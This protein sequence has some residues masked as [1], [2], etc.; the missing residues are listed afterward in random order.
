MH[1]FKQP[2]EA[3]QDFLPGHWLPWTR[4]LWRYQRVP[5]ARQQ[6]TGCSGR[7]PRF[8]ATG[9]FQRGS[10][11]WL[12]LVSV[13]CPDHSSKRAQSDTLLSCQAAPGTPMLQS[14]EVGFLLFGLVFKLWKST[15]QC[16]DSLGRL[17]YP[18]VLV[19]SLHDLSCMH[20]L[21]LTEHMNLFQPRTAMQKQIYSIYYYFWQPKGHYRC[22]RWHR[23]DRHYSVS[24]LLL[25][26][27]I[28]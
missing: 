10:Q 25:Y 14:M 16:S 13:E 4:N 28:I 22:S 23:K 18:V 5:P 7:A 12:L 19:T 8:P 3:S 15:N 17:C 6:E 20:A 26:H 27:F 2:S 24:S 9:S 21:L 11:K 1:Q